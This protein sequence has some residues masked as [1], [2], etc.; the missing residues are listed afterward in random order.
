[1]VTYQ[2]IMLNRITPFAIFGAGAVAGVYIIPK[3]T[4]VVNRKID[5]VVDRAV[6]KVVLKLDQRVAILQRPIEQSPSPY[7]QL[8]DQQK[9]LYDI[10]KDFPARMSEIERQLGTGIYKPSESKGNV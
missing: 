10:V 4:A 9:Q 8:L 5:G 2:D 6:D 1:M 7:Q 3:A